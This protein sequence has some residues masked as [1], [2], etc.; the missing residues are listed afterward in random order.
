M[1]EDDHEPI[2]RLSKAPA[3]ASGVTAVAPIAAS[4]RPGSRDSGKGWIVKK[5]KRNSTFW[6]DLLV[7]MGIAFLFVFAGVLIVHQMRRLSPKSPVGQTASP[8]PELMESASESVSVCVFPDKT[9][10]QGA[11][12]GLTGRLRVDIHNHTLRV[13]GTEDLRAFGGRFKKQAYDIMILREGDERRCR[14]KDQFFNVTD[15]KLIHVPS[16]VM[17]DAP[18]RQWFARINNSSMDL[19]Q[20]YEVHGRCLAVIFPN[21]FAIDC[22]VLAQG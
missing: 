20:N 3:S 19:S 8:V 16:V 14:P 17:M 5:R 21:G 7:N 10:K 4:R 9:S 15:Q 1:S 18:G 11:K 12:L 2:R 22:C 6:T 13:S